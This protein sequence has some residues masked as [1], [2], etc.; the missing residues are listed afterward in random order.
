MI[1]PI[2]FLIFFSSSFALHAKEINLYESLK[3]TITQQEISKDSIQVFKTL[4]KFYADSLQ[5]GKAVDYTVKYISATQDLTIINDHFFSKINQTSVYLNFKSRYKPEFNFLSLFYLFSGFLGLFIVVILNLK[6]GVDRS[7]TFL[8]SLFVLLHS[9]FIIHLS[10]YVINCQYYFPHTLLMSTVFVLLYGPLIYFYFKKTDKNYKLKWLDGLHF[11]PAVILFIYILP[12]YRLSAREKFNI[13]FNQ[14][15]ILSVEANFIIAGQ[16]ASLI[17]YAILIIKIY[18]GVKSNFNET[19]SRKLLWQRN[20]LAMFIAYIVAFILFNTTTSGIFDSI[21]VYHF[22]I[23]TMVGLVFYVAYITYAQPEIFKGELKLVDPMSLF[24]YKKSG[25]TKS[26]SEE[27]KEHLLIVLEKDKIY[28]Q[29]DINLNA[30]AGILGTNRHNTSQIINEHF[31]M[32]FF[33]LINKF[34]ID[35]AVKMISDEKYS[36][37][38]IIEIAYE[39][40]YNNKVTFN[41]AFKKEHSVTP[42]QFIKAAK[43]IN[44]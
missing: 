19:N 22:Q 44:N 16:I 3:V 43:K 6:K 12:F 21:I 10:L 40:G 29:N 30:L 33:E 20:I 7:S 41:K 23:L 38:N 24:K 14:V 5:A 11:L 34:R 9:L 8:M 27:L 31:N 39:V 13:L 28:K 37:L 25:L 32:N 2:V 35:E 18:D 4:A 15:D 26:F 1:K 42:T 17:I 36:D